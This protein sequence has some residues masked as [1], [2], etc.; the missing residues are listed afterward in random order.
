MDVLQGTILTA[1]LLSFGTLRMLQVE[2]TQDYNTGYRAF[3]AKE[4][5]EFRGR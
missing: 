2:L 4:K 3:L 1:R 5:P